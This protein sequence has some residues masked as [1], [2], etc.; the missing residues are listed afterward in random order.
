MS[1]FL[2]AGRNRALQSVQVNAAL[3]AFQKSLT[4]LRSFAP[5]IQSQRGV[6]FMLDLANQHGDAG[7]QRIFQAVISQ[8]APQPGL[9]EPELLEAME[10]ESVARV[11]RQF[12]D[13]PIT[14]STQR[15]REAFRATPL[16]SD[17]PFAASAGAAA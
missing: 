12:G 11:R 2:A 17:E 5:Q 14:D 6:A 13:G 15:R 8:G 10:Q 3:D 4:R 16:L 1:G 9:S 7:A